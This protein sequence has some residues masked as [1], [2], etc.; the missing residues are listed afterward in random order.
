MPRAHVVKAEGRV[1]AMQSV[2]PCGF[3]SLTIQETGPVENPKPIHFA[4]GK[5]A[6]RS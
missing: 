6:M 2:K 3:N 1:D 5:V 4:Q